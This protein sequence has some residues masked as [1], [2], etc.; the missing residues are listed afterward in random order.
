MYYLADEAG[1]AGGAAE[2]S[3]LIADYYA[4]HS[5]LNRIVYYSNTSG[6]YLEYP[7]E[8]GG[9]ILRSIPAPTKEEL[10]VSGGTLNV[11]PVLVSGQG[12]LELMYVPVYSPTGTYTGYLVILYDMDTAM[13]ENKLLDTETTGYDT[14]SIVLVN[15]DGKVTYATQQEFIGSMI[16]EKT[17]L[18]TRVSR[19]YVQSAEK[20]G[21]YQ[22][23]TAK[24]PVTTAWQEYA[25]HKTVYTLYL[26]KEET[27]QQVNYSDIFTPDPDAMRTEVTDAWK[28]AKE[29][30]ND[31]VLNRIN[32]GYYAHTL[33]GID[34]SGTILAAS[35][36]RQYAVGGNY[37]NMYD[38]YGVAYLQQAV[39][40]ANL[41]GGY[42]IYFTPSNTAWMS[43]ASEFRIGYVMPVDEDL[44]IAGMSAGEAHLLPNDYAAREDVVSVSRAVVQDVNTYGINAAIAKINSVPHA[45]GTLLVEGITTDVAAIGLLDYEG[46]MHTATY[47]PQL[48]GESA[49]FYKDIFGSSITR[50]AMMLAKSG[51]GMLYDY[52]W[53]KEKPGY[54]EV[55]LYS[56][57]PV[58][59]KYFVMS[60]AVVAVVKNYAQE[61]IVVKND[62]V[63]AA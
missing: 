18:D 23:Q 5:W 60:G 28:Y 29:A 58:N 14:C 3:D 7:I 17:P 32:S 15:R 46:I 50:Q 45:N 16:D 47:V 42:Q 43:E 36:E 11:G 52:Q 25:A 53:S 40:T 63:S 13:R 21:A 8:S 9:Q 12:W 20:S 39:H 31:A 49:T 56:V 35:P 24:G 44:F 22:Y 26:T 10:L 27:L 48:I 61:G 38:T 1:A 19:I 51:G 41:G 54:C 57:E 59:Q 62:S 2:I 55:W 34:R 30:G 37:L 4:A 6:T 33:Y